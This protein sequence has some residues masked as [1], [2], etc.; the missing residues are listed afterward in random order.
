MLIQARYLLADLKNPKNNINQL[1]LG[2]LL[3]KAPREF[4][5]N[6]EDVLTIKFDDTTDD[7][8]EAILK[9]QPLKV[10]CEEIVTT[11]YKLVPAHYNGEKYQ[12]SADVHDTPVGLKIT[13]KFHGQDLRQFSQ[14]LK[15]LFAN[16]VPL[17]KGF[18]RKDN[19][20]DNK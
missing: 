9:I 1:W 12:S 4:H 10:W 6:G 16:R 20:D 13:A 3:A 14:F 2:S 7:I 8:P 19:W 5:T 11:N 18:A 17:T 15:D